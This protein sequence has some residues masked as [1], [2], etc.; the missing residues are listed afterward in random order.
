M[1]YTLH[2]ND[3]NDE[4]HVLLVDIRC[5]HKIVIFCWLDIG[6]EA[7]WREVERTERDT[8]RLVAYFLALL[9]L[10]ALLLQQ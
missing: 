4:G 10:A 3:A 1:G 8:S 5:K 6:I 7:V 9:A 2:C